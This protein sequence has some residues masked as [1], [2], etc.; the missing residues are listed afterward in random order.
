MATI[1]GTQADDI[2]NG[3]GDGDIIRGFAGNDT[4]HGNGGDDTI[5]GDEGDDIVFG[6][7]GNDTFLY[8]RG[9][10]G[11]DQ[12]DLGSGGDVVRV[13]GAG[14][15]RITF[16]GSEVGNGSALESNTL[17][18]QDG[19][20]AVHLQAQ[21]GG[22]PS[23]PVS[24]FDDE[25]IAFLADTNGTF[26]VR[27]FATG[28]S[29]GSFFTAIVLGDSTPE[30]LLPPGSSSRTYY[31]G[32]GGNDRIIGGSREDFLVGGDG[33]DILYGGNS[34][35]S[36]VI[37]GANSFIGG[38]GNDTIF[39]DFDSDTVYFNAAT[40]GVDT[41][42]L[43]L[44]RGTNTVIST[45]AVGPQIRLTLATD[46][47]SN[48][49]NNDGGAA[50]GGD[51]GLAIRYQQEA[52]DGSLVGGV[53]RFGDEAM[54]FVGG[55]GQTFDVRDL[56]TGFQYGDY[57]DVVAFD[58]PFIQLGALTIDPTRSY[59]I[60]AGGSPTGLS[61]GDQRDVLRGGSGGDQL[62]GNGGDDTLFGGD[63]VDALRGGDGND[64]LI[65]G[66]GGD[67][68]VG[69]AGTDTVS[70]IDS[71]GTVFVNLTL[72]L[73]FNNYAQGD[74]YDGIENAIGSRSA[75]Y[76]IGDNSSNRLDGAEGNDILIGSLGPDVLVG[77]AGN[78]TASYEDNQGTVFVNLTLNRGYN[79][80][81]EGDTYEGIE[82]LKGGL[83]DDFFIGDAG[84]NRLEGA[85]GADTLL[86]AGGSD[87]FVFSH[88][89]GA[90][91]QWGSPNVDTILDFASGIDRIE[92]NSAVFAGLAPGTLGVGAF[93]TG[94]AAADAN[95]RII[96]NQATGQIFYDSDGSGAG[97]AM[98]FAILD[99]KPNIGASDFFVV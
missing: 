91:S 75:D 98:L 74:S 26:D 35:D 51:G 30:Q 54:I 44:S 85:M 42:D 39:G 60:Q 2:L 87:V 57:F 52:A 82:N 70:Y 37:T 78:D 8:T 43:G 29:R 31:D 79:N 93:V 73:G 56:V 46:L 84:N 55:A 19:G 11:A 33:D 14:N 99:T 77:G 13:L 24:R 38:P 1:N 41:V 28:I 7:A 20:L 63:G 48:A 27:D 10:D 12:V 61:G 66:R 32:G 80:A 88:A 83:F 18:G 81:A 21:Q 5:R 17:A 68:I 23:G 15:T 71:N 97:A 40:D 69:G 16:A 34:T 22:V 6:D 64:L 53:S 58:G 50:F 3:T 9:T 4:I 45:A 86:G 67:S 49:S 76:L 47:V 59:Y 90:T 65:G 62:V 72:G 95:D 25:S 96:Y 36:S 89:P 92:L 94:S